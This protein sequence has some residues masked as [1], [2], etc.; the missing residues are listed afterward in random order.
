MRHR[1]VLVVTLLA[2]AAVGLAGCGAGSE[3]GATASE[4]HTGGPTVPAPPAPITVSLPAS[5]SRF[6]ARGTGPRT[7]AVSVRFAGTA[8]PGR[9]IRI[10]GRCPQRR[11]V[12]HVAAAR[13]GRWA[14]LLRLSGARPR[15]ARHVA[16]GYAAPLSPPGPEV[17]VRL[18][19]P[20]P[21]QPR[22]TPT[23]TPAPAPVQPPASSGGGTITIPPPVTGSRGTMVLIGDSLL[24]GMTSEVRQALPGWGLTMNS[25]IGRGL[26]E[27]MR[28]L[29]GTTVPRGAVLGMG[30]F[31][32]DDPWRTTELRA[33]VLESL[34]RTAPNG[35]AVWS[36]I[37]APPINGQ[38]YAAANTVLRQLAG[39][40]PRMRLV[41]W[42][43]KVA[44]APGIL[45]P[46]RVH[47][48]PTGYRLRAR[49]YAQAAASCA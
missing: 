33:A 42:A 2:F 28:I 5:G 8:A 4:V 47:P 12:A 31:T 11:C 6:A 43:E 15:A 10:D 1:P 25:R 27:G 39:E 24:E 49:L 7:M 13:S 14:V 45:G 32:N 38:S 44:A 17:T 46:D 3:A 35:C 40:Q 19:G 34:R 37:S 21:A 36:T 48:T 29:A 41:P 30:L 22:P 18:S 16:V 23:K 9:R 26:A 20:P